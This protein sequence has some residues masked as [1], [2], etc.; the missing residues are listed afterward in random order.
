MLYTDSPV[1]RSEYQASNYIKTLGMANND[2]EMYMGFFFPKCFFSVTLKCHD[3]YYTL[4]IFVYRYH[5][6]S[7]STYFTEIIHNTIR[8]QSS[9]LHHTEH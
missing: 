4:T 3:I 2:L 6:M 8:T 1:W 9:D 5:Q 7:I